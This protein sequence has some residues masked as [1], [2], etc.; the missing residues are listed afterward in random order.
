MSKVALAVIDLQED[1]LPPDGS[2]AI[3]DGRSIIPKI[4]KLLSKHNW[5]A[6]INTQDWHPHNHISFAST[7]GVAPYSQ[8]QFTH[9]EGKIDATT[10]QAQVMTQ[11]VWPDHCVQD[12]AGA[13]LEQSFAD[14]FNQIQGE[15]TN[16][17]KGYL[18]DR[19]Y[20]SCFQDC[21]GL[22]HT[23]MQPYL[24]EK[25]ITDVVFVGLAYDFC[26]MNS[27]VDCAK[28]GFNTVVLKDYCKSVYPDKIA[29]T[30]KVYTDAGVRIVED[31][32]LDALFK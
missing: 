2:L 32:D 31:K 11:Y 25:G 3:A 6:I 13:A 15:K 8:L 28:D 17:K 19:E 18:V 20:Y 14:A 30:D 21:W 1:F 5:A 29:E 27:A 7:H 26:V 23:E 16:V 22:H 4:N 12:T 10:N 24:K 9:P